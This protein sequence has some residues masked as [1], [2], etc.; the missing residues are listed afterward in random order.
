MG[1]LRQA[2]LTDT[3]AIPL[4]GLKRLWSRVLGNASEVSTEEAQRDRIVLS[5]AGVGLE[6]ALVYLHRER[7][8]FD[9]FER[10]ILDAAGTA[11]DAAAMARF[12][13]AVVGTAVELVHGAPAGPLDDQALRQFSADGY[14]VLRGAI[15]PDEARDS[16]ALLWATIGADP[17]DPASWDRPHP[18]RHNIMVQRFR[19][20]PFERNRR[21]LRIRGAFEQLYGRRDIWPS[22]DRLGFNPPT[23]EASVAAPARL[24][25]DVE[26]RRPVPFLL[27]GVIYLNDVAS[28]QG[29]FSCVPGFHL[30][31]ADWLRT[32]PPGSDP[33]TQDLDA[34]GR[35]YVP[36]RAG[37]MVI[38]HQALPHGASRNS[39]G[40]PRLVQYFTYLPLPSRS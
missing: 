1:T 17:E 40:V 31:L 12:N 2:A 21:S 6:E 32:L 23:P 37:D 14:I 5:M 35:V 9:A 18:L 15:T 27:Q 34:L 20:E 38:W 36:G 11:I 26:L 16:A 19:G 8:S 22:V 28:D 33:Q 7:P 3:G 13:Q 4:Y 29:A 24:H 10:W 25:W 30:R 39:S